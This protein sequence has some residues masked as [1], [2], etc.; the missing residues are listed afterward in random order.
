MGKPVVSVVKV[1]TRY[2][3]AEVDAAVRKAVQLAGG[4]A[5]LFSPGD[6]VLLNRAYRMAVKGLWH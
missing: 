4:I 6:L 2:D 3:Q 1:G 5:H